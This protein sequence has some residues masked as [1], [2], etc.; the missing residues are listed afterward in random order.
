[1]HFSSQA[2]CI[3]NLTD[4]LGRARKTPGNSLPALPNQHWATPS[5]KPQNILLFLQGTH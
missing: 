3:G 2:T 4:P 5:G 1:M